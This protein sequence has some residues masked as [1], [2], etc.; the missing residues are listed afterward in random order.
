M[1]LNQIS[2][3]KAKGKCKDKN[4][5]MEPEINVIRDKKMGSN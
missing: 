5:N 1:N 2:I 4:H 3:R